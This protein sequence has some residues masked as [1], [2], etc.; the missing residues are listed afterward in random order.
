MA[1][2]KTL[3]NQLASPQSV[4]R[5]ASPLALYP[6]DPFVVLGDNAANFG[7]SWPGD[8]PHMDYGV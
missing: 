8:A 6:L 1:A 7:K 5:L 4:I 2:G 3:A